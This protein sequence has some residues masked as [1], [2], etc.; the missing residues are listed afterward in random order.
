MSTVNYSL[1]N[2]GVRLIDA[3]EAWIKGKNGKLKLNPKYDFVG[4]IDVSMPKRYT[5]G[6]ET[7][8]SIPVDFDKN[9]I[10]KMFK[11]FPRENVP[12]TGRK[13]K[14]RKKKKSRK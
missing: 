11:I 10:R 3:Q 12:T 1:K 7:D 6:K 2:K 9:R 4:K 14:Y 13:S 8:E 5:L